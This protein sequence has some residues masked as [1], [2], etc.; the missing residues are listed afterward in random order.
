MN[1]SFWKVSEKRKLLKLKCTQKNDDREP[2]SFALTVVIISNK[3]ATV[4]AKTQL[5]SVIAILNTLEMEL[6]DE[7]SGSKSSMEKFHI[8]ITLFIVFK[9]KLQTINKVLTGNGANSK[10]IV[11]IST[12]STIL[13]VKNDD[14]FKN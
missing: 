4:R 11:S 14:K 3:L 1:Y 8:E 13:D 2:F 7:I 9:L 10:E 12:M 5:F 6:D